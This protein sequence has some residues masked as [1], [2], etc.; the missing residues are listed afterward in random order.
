KVPLAVF[1]AGAFLGQGVLEPR[2]AGGEATVPFALERAI[3]VDQERKTE[4]RDA[5]LARIEAGRLTLE[6]DQV[7]LTTYRLRNGGE[8][9]AKVVV[10]H[11]RTQGMRLVKPPEG[12]DDQ[13][14]RGTALVPARIGGSASGELRVEERRAFQV[15]ADPLSPEADEAVKG[16]LADARA[17][18]KVAAPLAKAWEIRKALVDALREQEKLQGEREILSTAAEEAREGL[19]S[20]ARN[21]K[22]VEELRAKLAGRLTELGE[23][24]ARISKRLVELELQIAERRVALQD[25]L[26]AI[27]LTDPLAT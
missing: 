11:P 1:E 18:A 8:A 13:V 20:I 25:G 12:T 14:G 3:A 9:D 17:D 6:R 19:S 24:L 22:G 4:T 26:Q 5:R 10:R 15:A 27:K 2:A 23:K 21:T 16:Y 7:L